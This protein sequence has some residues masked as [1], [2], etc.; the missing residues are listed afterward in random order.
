METLPVT[1][2][3]LRHSMPELPFYEPED[4]ERLVEG[5]KKSA[6]GHSGR[7][8]WRSRRSARGEMVALE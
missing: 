5:A 2:K 6:R 1:V 7:A 4:F 8:A 3:L